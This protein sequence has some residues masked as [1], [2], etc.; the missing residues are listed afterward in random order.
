M[1][2]YSEVIKE[3]NSNSGEVVVF[4]LPENAIKG[5]WGVAAKYNEIEKKELFNV[6]ELEKIDIELEGDNLVISNLGN[7][8][9]VSKQ[10]SISIGEQ[11]ETA[12]VSLEVG[13][14]KRMRLTAPAGEYNVRI[15]DGTN[16]NTFEFNSVSL[17]GN[18]IGL[19]KVSIQS[20][21][22]EYPLVSL[23]L[24]VLAAGIIT[25]ASIKFFGK[26][27]GKNNKKRNK[28]LGKKARKK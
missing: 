2:F 15:S 26:N 16:E 9:V 25:V 12:L 28:N 1:N 24:I 14:T 10:I 13:E 5:H 27:S 22:K 6:M 18:V 8:P 7:V 23:F 21:W 3:G 19:E 4:E 11:D 17:T 20:F